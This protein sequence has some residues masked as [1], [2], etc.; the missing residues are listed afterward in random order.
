MSFLEEKKK[1]FFIFE[2]LYLGKI[3]NSLE[4]DPRRLFAIIIIIISRTIEREGPLSAEMKPRGIFNILKGTNQVVIS[5]ESGKNITTWKK[6]RKE[7]TGGEVERKKGGEKKKK[8]EERVREATLRRR[9]T[10]KGEASLSPYRANYTLC[11][12]CLN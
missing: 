2:K 1:K 10:D 9:D 4:I 6:F 11:P 8:Y 12:Y 3:N 7:T 5:V